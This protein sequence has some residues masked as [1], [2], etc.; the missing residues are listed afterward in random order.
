MSF[1]VGRPPPLCKTERMLSSSTS[2]SGLHLD[3]LKSVHVT[4]SKPSVRQ[5][6]GREVFLHSEGLH[7]VTVEMFTRGPNHDNELFRTV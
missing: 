6:V 2:A 5:L 1:K 3:I 4:L 7:P